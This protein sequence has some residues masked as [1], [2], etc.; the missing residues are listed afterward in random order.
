MSHNTASRHCLFRPTNSKEA[1]GK[2]SSKVFYLI[3][4]EY[5][6]EKNEQLII[7]E[8]QNNFKIVKDLLL[9]CGN[10]VSEY[11]QENEIVEL[12]VNFLNCKLI[13][14]VPFIVLVFV[15]WFVFVFV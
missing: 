8:L 12:L 6:S 3:I 5:P 2:S 13:S 9:R 7:K 15:C 11:T 1:P 4:K 10:I 14:S